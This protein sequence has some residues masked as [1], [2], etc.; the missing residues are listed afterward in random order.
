[1]NAC[2]RGKRESQGKNP[3]FHKVI[4]NCESERLISDLSGRDAIRNNAPRPVEKLLHQSSIVL[5][6]GGSCS[7]NE[8]NCIEI[9]GA[10]WF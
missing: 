4:L 8:M 1:L 10:E 5:G 6:T 7:G 9:S 2:E 3:S